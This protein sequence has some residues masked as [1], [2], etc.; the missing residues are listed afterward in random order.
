MP[1]YLLDSVFET[2]LLEFL[3]NLTASTRENNSFFLKIIANFH[4]IYLTVYIKILDKIHTH[5]YVMHGGQMVRCTFHN[6]PGRCSSGITFILGVVTASQLLFTVILKSEGGF[7][8]CFKE[9]TENKAETL[10]VLYGRDETM[11]CVIL[12]KISFI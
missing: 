6:L 7:R 9:L 3:K 2:R 12:W 10:H 8:F 1:L 11:V 4:L 5:I